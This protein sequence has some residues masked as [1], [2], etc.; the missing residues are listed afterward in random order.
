M[1]ICIISDTHGHHR[2]LTIPECDVLICAGDITVDGEWDVIQDFA[3]WMKEQAVKHKIVIFGNHE[4]NHSISYYT[5]YTKERTLTLLEGFGIR[6]LEDDGITLDGVKFYGSPWQHQFA[7]YD[8]YLPW[9][10]RALVEKWAKIPNDT[11]VLITHTPPYGILDLVPQ[12]AVAPFIKPGAE[13][14][15]VRVGDQDLLAR[16]A[17]LPNLKAHVFGHIHFSYG[18]HIKAGIKF[19]N[20]AICTEEGEPINKPIVIDIEV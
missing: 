15:L 20:A 8:F 18:E 17:R 2:K 13:D 11:N 16:V 14:D 12:K 5:N 6:Y 3:F 1:K 7:G 9:R 10:S 4:K 19:V